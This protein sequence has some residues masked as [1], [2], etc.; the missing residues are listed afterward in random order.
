MTANPH[1]PRKPSEAAISVLRVLQDAGAVS[2]ATAIPDREIATRSGL[3][4]R[5]IIDLALELVQCRIFV[6]PC[7]AGRYLGAR[8]Y[9]TVA[10][11]RADGRRNR[12][13]GKRVLR[14]GAI[15]QRAA[16]ALEL[17]LG[18]QPPVPAGQQPSLFGSDDPAAK[19]KR[20]EAFTR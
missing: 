14:R 6:L 10:A 5:E 7:S 2:E 15:M 3:H 19:S 8:T 20:L 17:Y 12:R 1:E 11:L 16:D 18:M 13:R 9:D 4:E